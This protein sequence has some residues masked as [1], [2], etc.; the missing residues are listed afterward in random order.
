M[1]VNYRSWE[2]NVQD[3]FQRKTQKDR[4]TF[5]LNFALLAP[6]SHNSQPWKF[7]VGD[8]FIMVSADMRRRLKDGDS[9]D[10][11]LFISLGCAITNILVAGDYY[12]LRGVVT[13]FP[14]ASNPDCAARISFT[15]S[16]S[17]SS[18][19]HH[20]IFAI[21]KRTSNRNKYSKQLPDETFIDQAKRLE[22]PT[23]HITFASEPSIKNQLA[24]V[25]LAA[26]IFAM[27]DK[28]FREELS[29]YV[30]SNI[31]KSFIGMPAFGMGIP[32]PVSLFAPRMIQFLNMNKLSLKA[33]EKMFKEFTPTLGLISTEADT[34]Q[35]WLKTG[36]I[37]EHIVLEACSRGI[38][39]AVWA[40]PIQIGEYYRDLQ[41]ILKIEFRPQMFF[42]I[43]Y[44]DRVTPHS[45]RIPLD[46]ILEHL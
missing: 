9:N 38:A 36:E 1:K 42:R 4:L 43:G 41:T 6:S 8:D 20:L 30:K 12:G 29:H 44:T 25:A 33:D 22:T 17:P 23:L 28:Y 11:Q 15:T 27:E 46:H 2:V 24:D 26:G 39:S 19:N 34:K 35:D 10:R 18:D 45:P 7:R 16:G 13:Y 31:T 32:T 3:F 37:Y 21:P 40:A 5:L 14:E